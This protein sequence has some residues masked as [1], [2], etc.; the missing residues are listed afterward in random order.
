[1]KRVYYLTVISIVIISFVC[2]FLVVGCKEE[3]ASVE[4]GVEEVEAVEEVE[5][6]AEEIAAE[7][8]PVELVFL[9]I[10]SKEEKEAEL[11]QKT[12]DAFNADNE[13]NATITPIW[14]GL[15]VPSRLQSMLEAGDP[16]DLFQYASSLINEM[17]V[18]DGYALP[19][20]DF[21]ATEKA[22]K[23]DVPLKDLFVDGLIE[24]LCTNPD[25]GKIYTFPF[26]WY[27]QVFWYNKQYARELGICE[28]CN[29]ID[30]DGML[31]KDWSEF[32]DLCEYLKGKGVPPIVADGGINYYNLTY[33][34]YLCDRVMGPF[35]LRDAV[36]DES[37][38]KLNDP[39]FLEAAKK[40]EQL[41]TNGYFIE[42]A[43]GYQWPAGQMDW[44]NGAGFMLLLHTFMPQ[45][46]AE[47]VAERDWEWGCFPF[48]SSEGWKGNRF[49]LDA[50]DNGTA[51]LSSCE[52]PE[53]AFEFMKM[54]MT[55]EYQT[56][57][58]EK[59]LQLPCRKGIPLPE[60]YAD[61]EKILSEQTGIFLTYGMTPSMLPSEYNAKV[62]LPLDDQLFFGEITAEEF[63]E[64]WKEGHIAFYSE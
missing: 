24:N 34:G 18:P 51:I 42:G 40:L 49:D 4:E 22:Y 58:A 62:M 46:V 23:E 53:A 10:N 43:D 52:I 36:N 50:M 64:K 30:A 35:S 27:S 57:F 16:P 15:E 29:P 9:S 33:Y 5:E 6:V 17:L 7:G 47:I 21:I 54:T 11:L 56:E 60:I 61:L 28:D 8:E 41:A 19:L 31:P 45:Q 3:G 25:D 14:G 20:D 13:W 1:M 39:G 59:I 48:P 63:I 55:V 37:G 26:R 12:I 38:E 2:S 44:A 32:I